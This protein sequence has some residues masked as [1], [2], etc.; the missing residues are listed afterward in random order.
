MIVAAAI[1]LGWAA[2]ARAQTNAP[3]AEDIV[4][5]ATRTAQSVADVP[6]SVQVLDRQAI[7]NSG[8]VTVDQVF[9]NVAGVDL[10]GSGLPG[11]AIRLS[12]RGLTPG[13]QSERVLVLVDGRRVNDAYLG[14]PEFLL[15][16]ADNLERVEILRGP[17]SALYGSNAEGGVINIVT[18]RGAD[19]PFTQVT[20]AAGSHQTQAYRLSHG[21]KSGALDYF[22]TASHADTAGYMR[23]SDGTRRDWRDWNVTGNLGWQF[24]QDAELRLF[25]GQLT[26]EGADENSR[27]ETQRDYAAALYRLRWDEQRDAELILRG[28]RNGQRDLYDWKYPGEGIY[29]QETL[30]AEVQQSLWVAARH[31]ATAGA[32]VR[33][34][35]VNIDEV[36]GKIV[37]DTTAGG[38][39]AQD[40]VYFGD[41]VRLTL[42][43][44]D[45]SAADYGGEWCPRVG[46]LWRPVEQA[47][48]YA[49]WNRAYR[50][51]S[52]SDRYVRTEYNGAL[53]VGN[54]ELKP[55]TLTACEVGV[56]VRPVERVRAEL[57]VFDNEMRDSFDFM[58]DPDGVFR[59]HNVTRSWT[60]GVESS[61]S[62]R[63]AERMTAFANYAYTAGEYRQGSMPDIEGNRLAYLAPHKAAAGV[64]F[65]TP[66]GQT[67]ALSA[68]HVAARY[69]DAQNTPANR[70]DDYVTLD[71]RSR[72]PVGKHATVTLSVDNL[73]DQTYQNFPQVNQPGTTILAGMELTF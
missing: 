12:L 64:E 2:G 42:G 34:D 32:D 60:R 31:L 40:E 16:P 5:T 65:A 24:D 15:M 9:R 47:E 29:R 61:L 14:N 58:R 50:A 53:F 63:I 11:A 10:Q 69:G 39:Y 67:H 70:M 35:G 21:W 19:T 62:C 71:W 28:Y 45:D 18:R 20:A 59:N 25:L 23:N 1:G 33:R 57:A 13:Y 7:V 55:E 22:L 56:R 6:A 36:A 3:R 43:L 73:L 38:V 4:V 8:A 41:S 51:P 54:P 49:S 48:A 27:R 66:G 46:L 17:A 72:V 52:L 37:A 44:R 26:G 30:G 68:R